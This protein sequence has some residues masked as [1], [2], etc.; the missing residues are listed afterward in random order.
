[1]LYKRRQS[2]DYTGLKDIA[3]RTVPR[4]TV[5]ET[6]A[7]IPDKSNFGQM[8]RAAMGARTVMTLVREVP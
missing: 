1:M 4:K 3:E 6:E 2:D 8:P 7:G 5:T